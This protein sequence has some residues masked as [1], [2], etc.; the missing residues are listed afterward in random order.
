[1]KRDLDINDRR[2]DKFKKEIIHAD[3]ESIYTVSD[4]DDK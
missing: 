2:N 4:N 3:L 1:M